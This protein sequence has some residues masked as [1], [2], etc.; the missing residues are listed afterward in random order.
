MFN[1]TFEMIR[2]YAIRKQEKQ[3]KNLW[4][5]FRGTNNKVIV[6][7][8]FQNPWDGLSQLFLIND[9]KYNLSSFFVCL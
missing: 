8:L 2:I 4:R 5:S 7:T 3:P 1:S 6:T 9:Q